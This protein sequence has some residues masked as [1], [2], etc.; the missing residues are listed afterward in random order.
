MPETGINGRSF[1]KVDFVTRLRPTFAR[2]IRISSNNM[3]LESTGPRLLNR[4]GV[5]ETLI[6]IGAPVPLKSTGAD[7]EKSPVI[8][9]GVEFSKPAAFPVISP[10]NVPEIVPD[11]TTLSAVIVVAKIE[12]HLFCESPSELDNDDG[13][14]LFA[15]TVLADKVPV[16]AAS[17]DM[18]TVF[19]TVTTVVLLFF[20]VRPF[21]CNNPWTVA[22]ELIVV[23]VDE[24]ITASTCVLP[25]VVFKTIDF[26]A[27]KFVRTALF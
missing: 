16:T 4:S 23:P 7:S 2:F 5:A 15:V 22:G 20:I 26:P 24:T 3:L 13:W 8:V 14:M 1:M 27:Y 9:I 18:L 21:D 10:E 19:P 6:L 11:T 12:F 17:V 25:A